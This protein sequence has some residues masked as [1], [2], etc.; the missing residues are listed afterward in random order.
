MAM[1]IPPR[2]NGDP[3]Q[4]KTD[5]SFFGKWFEQPYHLLLFGF[6]S[7][8]FFSSLL[9][10]VYFLSFLHWK[11]QRPPTLHLMSGKRKS[12]ELS[13]VLKGL[14]HV[15]LLNSYSLIY[16]PCC[17][18]SLIA[19]EQL[20]C[21]LTTLKDW[22]LKARMCI[23]LSWFY[24]ADSVKLPPFLVFSPPFWD[25][26]DACYRFLTFCHFKGSSKGSANVRQ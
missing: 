2:H 26:H 1:L 16:R 11:V 19:S 12:V 20:I 3:A 9:S 18:P 5:T 8:Y 25:I 22:K 6:S 10:C 21:M 24:L 14:R 17:F 15:T 13:Q 23:L 7:I 4:K